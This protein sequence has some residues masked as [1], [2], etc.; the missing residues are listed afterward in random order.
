MPHP[1]KRRARYFGPAIPRSNRFLRVLIIFFAPLREPLL[2]IQFHAKAQ[3]KANGAKKTESLTHLAFDCVKLWA[4]VIR[5]VFSREPGRKS[6]PKK[7]N[8]RTHRVLVHNRQTVS[9]VAHH[10]KVQ[11]IQSSSIVI[12][13]TRRAREISKLDLE[14][15]KVA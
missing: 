7:A 2:A 14:W 11:A 6:W 5:F 10:V 9:T 8:A 3:S 4:S 1:T 15:D 13:A 12:A